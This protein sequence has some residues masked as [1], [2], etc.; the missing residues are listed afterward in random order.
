[1]G[2]IDT[3]RRGDLKEKPLTGLD[4]VMRALREGSEEA[5]RELMVEWRHVL[6][7]LACQIMGDRAAADDVVQE[8]FLIIWNRRRQYDPRRPAWPWIARI[9]RNLC[10]MEWRRHRSRINE[11]PSDLSLEYAGYLYSRQHAPD[12]RSEREELL[13]LAVQRISQLPSRLR[14]VVQ[15]SIFEGKTER[16][17][18]ELLGIAAGTVKSRKHR[19]LKRL[20]EQ[21]DR[22]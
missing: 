21:M 17:I 15:L 18:A 1:M 5:L 7:S 6:E 8:T 12:V 20:R 10:Y 9:V 14:E 16:E 11:R 4:R 3:E 19:A 2:I 13:G 22:S